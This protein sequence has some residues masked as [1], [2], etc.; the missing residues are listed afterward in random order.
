MVQKIYSKMHP[1][2]CTNTHD[3]VTDL[4]NHGMVKNTKTW[5]SWERNKNWNGLEHLFSLCK[6]S[7]MITGKA[8]LNQEQ[9]MKPHRE[10][11]G[12]IL[13]DDHFWTIFK[14]RTYFERSTLCINTEYKYYHF[15]SQPGSKTTS[16]NIA[17]LHTLFL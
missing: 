15:V 8:G 13:E 1:V 5:I 7:D 9:W 17:I 11:S 16:R 14:N 6:K 3:D 2:S 4:V 10:C 12:R